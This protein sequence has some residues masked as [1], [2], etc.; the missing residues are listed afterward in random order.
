M[1]Q[2]E[3]PLY[4]LYAVVNH[5][6]GDL[7]GHYYA[8]THNPHNNT[9]YEM[10][11]SFVG[12]VDESKIITRNAYMLFYKRRDVGRSSFMFHIYR[13]TLHLHTPSF[14]L[15]PRIMHHAGLHSTHETTNTISH[16]ASIHASLLMNAHTRAFLQSGDDLSYLDADVRDL[17]RKELTSEQQKLVDEAKACGCVIL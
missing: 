17:E 1:E 15:A 3:P 8:Y 4:D 10:N 13:S 11:D 2:K 5:S 16:T 9:W 14:I 7:G 12:S 6:G